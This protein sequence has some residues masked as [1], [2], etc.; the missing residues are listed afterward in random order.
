MMIPYIT[1]FGHNFLCMRELAWDV[2]VC[3][4][5]LLEIVKPL[6]ITQHIR[7]TF[8]VCGIGQQWQCVFVNII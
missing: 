7:H 3:V 1:R 5:E 4:V 8:F 6:E 2:C